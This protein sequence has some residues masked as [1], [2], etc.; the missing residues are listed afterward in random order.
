[1]Y[2]KTGD[3]CQKIINV[4]GFDFRLRVKKRAYSVEIVVLDPERNSIDGLLVSDE[5][6]L[7]TALDILKQTIY[8]W[9]EFNTDEQDKLINLIMK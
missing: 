4:D 6:D 8:E 7:Y 3:V 9:I 2:Y 5:N 1:M